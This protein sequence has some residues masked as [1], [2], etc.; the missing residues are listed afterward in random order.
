[1]K[2][3]ALSLAAIAAVVT[4]GVAA[5]GAYFSNTAYIKN[6]TFATG[7]VTLASP[8]SQSINANNLAPGVAQTFDRSI[9]Y[10]GSINADLYIGVRG[11]PNSTDTDYFADHLNVTIYDQADWS[12]KYNGHANGLSTS[13]SKIAQDIPQWTTKNYRI[14]FTLDSNFTS[15]GLNNTN[16]EFV[17]YAVQ[18]GGTVPATAPYLNKVNIQLH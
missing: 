9:G 4:M 6:N 17:I 5:T 8:S 18:T 10:T 15:Q 14:V 3:I 1:M 16:T 13:W 2:R 7:T 11:T 12:I